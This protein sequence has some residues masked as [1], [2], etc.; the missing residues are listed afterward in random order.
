[1]SNYLCFFFKA[2]E[3]TKKE[4]PATEDKGTEDR[5]TKGKGKKGQQTGKD[6]N[7]GEKRGLA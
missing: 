2:G 4:T 6:G 7:T 5:K 3:L 1:V